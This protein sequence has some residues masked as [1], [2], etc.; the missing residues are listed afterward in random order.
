MMAMGRQ[1]D[2][3]QTPALTVTGVRPMGTSHYLPEPQ[4]P[5]V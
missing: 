3:M 4:L 5:D 1:I 2:Q